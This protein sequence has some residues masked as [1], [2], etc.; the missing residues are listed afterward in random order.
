MMS[1]SEKR[2][3][4]RVV[5]S[6]IAHCRIGNRFT[7]DSVI[8][9]SSGGLYLR[10]REIAK[11]GTPVRVAL[12]LPHDGGPKFC[13]LVGAVV[14]EDRDPFG[15]HKGLGV[16]LDPAQTALHDRTVLSSFVTRAP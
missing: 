12:A 8:D 11:K 14:R 10:T 13:T 6:L 15:K 9:L 7:R 1:N 16:C 3:F 5:V 2:G 4:R